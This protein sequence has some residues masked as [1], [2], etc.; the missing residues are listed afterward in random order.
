MKTRTSLKIKRLTLALLFGLTTCGIAEEPIA[1]YELGWDDGDGGK[2]NGQW[3]TVPKL[4]QGN[5]TIQF[6]NKQVTS[7][8]QAETGG[9]QVLK[10]G[11]DGADVG[12]LAF[13][14]LS[15]AKRRYVL[16]GEARC[17][18]VNGFVSITIGVANSNYAGNVAKA[19][20]ADGRDKWTGTQDWQSFALLVDAPPPAIPPAG[21]TTPN[22]FIAELGLKQD[23]SGTF[24]LRNLRLEVYGKDL[25]TPTEAEIIPPHSFERV[26][27]NS[28]TAG[29]GIGV[30][31]CFVV[32]RFCEARRRGNHE[33][34][35]RRIASL[36]APGS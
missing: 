35:L 5:S 27:L 20:M 6:S 8:V 4:I 7:E 10:T 32:L 34:E 9:A 3:H 11:V 12:L 24:Y 36:D 17:E 18:V 21:T 15:N 16:K 1:V 2:L 26:N 13:T 14:E 19:S 31:G 30:L 22:Q 28:F 25:P 29:I 33:K 23:G